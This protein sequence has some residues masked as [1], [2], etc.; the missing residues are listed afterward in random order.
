[1][2]KAAKIDAEACIGTLIEKKSH[3]CAAG[4][5]IPRRALPPLRSMAARA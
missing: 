2:S 3:T 5:R 4:T 1:V